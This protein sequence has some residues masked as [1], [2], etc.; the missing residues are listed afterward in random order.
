MIEE[1]V[2]STTQ[3]NLHLI[4][5]LQVRI[6][7]GEGKSETLYVE[8]DVCH[9]ILLALHSCNILQSSL[10]GDVSVASRIHHLK[11]L[12]LHRVVNYF[13]FIPNLRVN[14]AWFAS[15]GQ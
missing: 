14:G 12:L 1:P 2:Y 5:R 4:D 7:F 11:G 6:I 8:N 10:I 9:D 13:Y 15:L 3:V